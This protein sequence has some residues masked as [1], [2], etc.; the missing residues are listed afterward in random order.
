MARAVNEIPAGLLSECSSCSPLGFLL[1]QWPGEIETEAEADFSA[2]IA[3]DIGL[4]LLDGGGLCGDDPVDEV[5]DGN[6]S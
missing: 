2:W 3:G 4:Q 1:L 5:A 6:N